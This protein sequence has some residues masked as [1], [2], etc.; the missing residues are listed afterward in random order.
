MYSPNDVTEIDK[1][2]KK[3]GTLTIVPAVTVVVLAVVVFVYGQLQKSDHLWKLTAALTILGVGYGLFF[4]GVYVR[5]VRLYRRHVQFMLEGR[6]RETTGV[7]KSFADQ[8][9]DRD[10]I[11]C[12]AVM[13]NVGTADDPEDDRLFYYDAQFAR[14]DIPFGTLVTILSNDKMIASFQKS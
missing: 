12:H 8:L 2:L 14:P 3:R 4:Y 6:K 1:L 10:G 11:L 7:F 13:I 9:S 5:P